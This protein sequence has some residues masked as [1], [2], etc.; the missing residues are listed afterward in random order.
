MTGWDWCKAVLDPELVG[1]YRVDGQ[2]VTFTTKK[3]RR[4]VIAV[5]D[6]ADVEHG[7]KLVEAALAGEVP[8]V[9]E[10][11]LPTL[12]D[13]MVDAPVDVVEPVAIEPPKAPKKPRAKKAIQTQEVDLQSL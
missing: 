7:K 6:W 5:A 13:V 12:D 4:Y 1:Y 3:G 10:V 11:A 9:A 2:K 8:P